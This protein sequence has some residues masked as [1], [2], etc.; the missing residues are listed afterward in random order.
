MTLTLRMAR[1]ADAREVHAI[2]AHHVATGYGSFDEVAPPVEEMAARIL[3]TLGK[4]LPFLVAERDGRII[5][6]ASAG[7]FRPRIAY[8]F[9]L[10]DSVYVAPDA[11]GH[12]VGRALLMGVVE[13]ASR[14]AWRQ[15]IA[16]IGG[17]EQL[18][19]GS[20]AL[21]RA[22]GFTVQGTLHGVG[23]KHGGWVDL[24]LMQRPLGP[25][26]LA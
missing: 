22:C 1:G 10:E 23:W 18:N 20:V 15:M 13:A 17:G 8:R 9:T 11:M 2:Y 4:D 14:G 12:G 19:P 7:A 24:I 26:P 21:H 16:A 6:W 5:G 25:T 3:E